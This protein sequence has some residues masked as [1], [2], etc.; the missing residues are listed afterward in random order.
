MLTY[1]LDERKNESLYEYL[2]NCM[3]ED[4]INGILQP[5][6]KLP[7][8]RA[9]ARNHGISIVTVENTYG[10]LMAEGYIYS[11][12]KSGFFVS[13]IQTQLEPLSTTTELLQA[14][15]YEP[16]F[17]GINLV[18]NHTDISC[19]PFSVWAKLN[20]QVLTEQDSGLLT[21]PPMGGV[22][23]LRSAIAKH[24]HDFR[25][26]NVSYE[27][28]IVG[29]GSEYLYS[30]IVQLLG[31]DR[32]YGLENPCSKKI[33]NIYQSLGVKITPLSMDD[34][35]VILTPEQLNI[36]DIIQISPSHHFPTGI[37]TSVSRRYGLLQWANERDS[38]YIIEDDYDSEFR[39]QGKPIP[40][41]FSMDTTDKVIYFNTFTKSLASTIRIS[42]MVLPKKLLEIYKKKLGFYS[43]TV[44]NFEQYILAS[45]IKDRHFE[46]HINRMRN[47]YRNLRDHL[48]ALF[49]Q[50]TLASKIKIS[51]ENAGLHFLLHIDTRVSDSELKELALKHE[52]S[53]SFLSDYYSQDFDHFPA[54]TILQINTINNNY[55]HTAIIN[56]SGLNESTLK[57]VVTGLEKAWTNL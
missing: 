8:K 25:G 48:I 53:V 21:P 56:Y 39:L 30:Q 38:H 47:N 27:Q 18:S 24:L 9:F 17:S 5:D 45:F 55:D 26:I 35:G 44:S 16:V 40:S 37:V 50:S 33:K 14:P 36:P 52:I 23:E 7:S 29:A 32:I 3:K 13:S 28:I 49:M 43:C 46:K 12:P 15:D 31:R 1:S 6:E 22:V 19:F 11:K 34:E 10:Q 42:Y 54:S 51:E 20:R 4:I 41:L 2:Y 57:A